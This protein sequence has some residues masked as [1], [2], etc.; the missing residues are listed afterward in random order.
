MPDERTVLNTTYLSLTQELSRISYLLKPIKDHPLG[1]YAERIQSKFVDYRSAAQN[2]L[3]EMKQAIDGND[4]SLEDGWSAYLKLKTELM[5]SLSSELLAIIGG[6]YLIKANL[7][8]MGNFEGDSGQQDRQP[9]MSFSEMAQTLVEDLATRGGKGWAPVLIVGEERL[10][11]SV[12]EIIRLRF[13]ACDIWHLPFTAHEYG[14][15]VAQIRPPDLLGQFRAHVQN[16]VDPRHHTE[17]L[18]PPDRSCFLKAIQRL[19]DNYYDL[20]SD[21]ERV[22]FSKV[23]EQDVIAL[24]K[25]QDTHLCRL[26]AD[27]FAT[28]F[29]GPAYVHALL[30]LRF[31]PDKTLYEP[32][33]AMPPFADRFVFALETLKWMINGPFLDPK[34]KPQFEDEIYEPTGIPYLWRLTVTSAQRED[35]YKQ[36][37]EDYEP[38]L[39][40]IRQILQT[41]FSAS[42]DDT[43]AHWRLAKVL[44]NGLATTDK[45]QVDEWPPMG[46]IMNA[47]WSSLWDQPTQ[48]PT[49]Q[50]NALRL[51]KKSD[52]SLLRGMAGRP[53]AEKKEEVGLTVEQ[54]VKIVQN[55]LATDPGNNLKFIEMGKSGH[56][57]DDDILRSLTNRDLEAYKAYVWLC[58][59]PLT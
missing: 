47:A 39:S 10:G 52:P 22:N 8:H 35:C 28:F 57:L 18:H 21:E 30:H 23:H 44:K 50:Y 53:S 12:A 29:I 26:F 11:H 40:Q 31:I 59:R 33:A 34:D 58:M 3:R 49:I 51:L 41:S 45:L 27:A 38:W 5:P 9:T 19:W 24:G 14:Y 46:A 43:L 54:A 13:P 16:N 2:A 20:K 1:E 36:I 48:W 42:F 37:A 55:A 32:S 4:K 56:K 6:V 17:N 7:D 15:L 25:Q